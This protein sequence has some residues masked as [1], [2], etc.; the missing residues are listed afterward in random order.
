MDLPE[1]DSQ[2]APVRFPVC[3][4]S[5]SSKLL[6]ILTNI[7]SNT[8]LSDENPTVLSIGSGT[9]ILEAL[10]LAHSQSRSLLNIEGVEVQQLGG[11][12]PVNRYLPEQAIYTVRGTWDVVSRLHDP[13]VTALMFVYPRQP[14]LI[15]E[16]IKVISEQDLKVQVIV[17][18]GPMADWEVFEPCFSA[19]IGTSQFAVSEK[20]QGAEAG[21]DE[22]ELLVVVRRTVYGI[23]ESSL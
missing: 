9:G 5:I 18:L 12:A 22:Y 20:R 14:G 10:L 2:G 1:L 8:T 3:C 4:L 11:K 7:F 6:Q 23:G 13:D 21:L 17:W 16:Y 15:S 19:R